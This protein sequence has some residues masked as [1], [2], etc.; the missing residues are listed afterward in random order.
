MSEPLK[1]TLSELTDA[2]LEHYGSEINM[3]IEDLKGIDPASLSADQQENREQALQEA[4]SLGY[5]FAIERIRRLVGKLE[6]R[7]QP[8]SAEQAAEAAKHRHV[9]TL[10]FPGGQIAPLEVRGAADQEAARAI[11][12]TAFKQCRYE[13]ID[14]DQ[15]NGHAECFHL[16]CSTAAQLAQ[17]L[18]QY[19]AEAAH[20]RSQQEERA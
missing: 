3:I 4:L 7:V 1:K 16:W 19:Q 17:P 5:A 8:D 6:N 2:E 13:V 14:G 9:F 10:T 18:H 20:R 11:A 12:R 15:T